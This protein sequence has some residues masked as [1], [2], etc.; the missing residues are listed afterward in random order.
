VCQYTSRCPVGRHRP[1]TICPYA[2]RHHRTRS[3]PDMYRTPSPS[4]RDSP[5]NAP[6]QR[7][8]RGAAPKRTPQPQEQ[9]RVHRHQNRQVLLE[10]TADAA[11][12]VAV[13]YLFKPGGVYEVVADRLL[14]KTK[15]QRR[16][17]RPRGHWLCVVL[18]DAARSCET[19]TYIDL[20]AQ[21][22]EQGLRQAY[23][24]PRVVAKVLAQCAATS[25]KLLLA[26]T[27]FGSANFPIVLRGLIALVCP[28]LDRCPTQADVRTALLGPFVADGLRLAVTGA[29]PGSQ[30]PASP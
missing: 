4:W 21:G 24:M 13:T 18:D 26:P 30:S 16:F 5:R 8:E 15:T 27:V 17:G 22:V 11:A 9:R 10:S 12:E 2:G 29:S 28:N 14:D 25:A 1:G 20:A 19:G 3:I 23:G 7:P 6:S